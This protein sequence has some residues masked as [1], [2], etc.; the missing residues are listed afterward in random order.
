MCPRVW[1][2]LQ[3]E[4]SPKNTFREQTILMQAM[5]QKVQAKGTAIQT[6]E[7]AY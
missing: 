3:F 1:Q 5:P 7:E 4:R 6:S 2:T